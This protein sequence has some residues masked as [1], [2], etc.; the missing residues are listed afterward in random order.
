MPLFIRLRFL[1]CWRIIFAGLVLALLGACS[2]T[3]LAYT[4]GH[5]LAWWWLSDY[6]DVQGED[7]ATLRRAVHQAHDWHRRE[8]L[9]GTIELLQR[10]QP[11]FAGDLPP[12]SA[13]RLVDE[14]MGRAVELPGLVQALDVPALQL[15]A[16]LSPRQLAEMERQFAKSNRKFRSKYIEVSAQ[17]LLDLR[18]DAGLSRAQWIYGSLGRQ[19]EQALRAALV[20]APWDARESYGWRLRRQQDVLQTLRELG[21][22][23]ANP[24]ATRSALRALLSRLIDPQEP[25]ERARV[26]AMRQQSCQLMA[27]LHASTT[28]AQRAKAQ[29]NLRNSALDLKALMPPR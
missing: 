26:L 20:A 25:V 23:Q 3:R 9:A 6:I 28:A 15:L 21:Q 11:Q 4:N 24:E 27:Q 5:E 10:W 14:V 17:D 16:R 2:T 1:N 7:R 13:C 18:V 22:T 12:E 29:D 19:Q 8:Q